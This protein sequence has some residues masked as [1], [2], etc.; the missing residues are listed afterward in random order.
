MS[1]ISPSAK[2]G[3]EEREKASEKTSQ[4]GNEREAPIFSGISPRRVPTRAD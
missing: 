2:E 4:A 3:R 1:Q